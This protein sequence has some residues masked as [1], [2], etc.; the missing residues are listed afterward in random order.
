MMARRP[1]LRGDTLPLLGRLW[2]EWLAPHRATLAVVLVL[3]TVVGVATGLYPALI[4]AAFDAFDRKDMSALA[5]GPLIVIAVTSARGFALFGQTVLT[6]RVVTRVE[7]DMQAALYAHLIDADLAQLGRESPAAFTQRFTTDF[8]F[9]KEALTRI[10]TVLLRDVAMLAA[11]VIALVWMDPL[12]TLAAAVT[13]PLVAGPVNRIG[14][15]LRQVSTTTQEQMGATASLITESLQGARVAKTYALEGYLKDRAAQALD[16]V[17]RLKM[18]AA[19]ARGRLDP[20]MEIGG[21]LAVAGVLVLVGQR[22][23]SGDRTVGDFTGYVAALLLA[24]QPARALGTLNAI[25]QEAAAALTRY[26]ALMDEQPTIR[27]SASAR[28][29]TVSRGE[30]RFENVHFR[31]RAD[32]PALEGI[33]LVVPAG[34]TTALVGRS[35]SGKSSL[36]NLVPRLQDVTAGRVLIDGTDVR[37]VTIASLRAAIAVVSQEVVLFDDTVAANIGFGRP[38]ATQDE[39]EAAARAAAAHG[40]ISRLGEGYAFRVGPGGGRLSG[41]E[42][43]RISL[44]R[45]F[46]KNAPILLLDEATSALDSESEH[47]V[48]EA[49]ERLMRGRTTLV[50]AHRLSTV[51]EANRIAVLEA[52]RVIELGRHD[53]LVAASGTY[54]RL[55]RL[56]LSDDSGVP[57]A[58]AAPV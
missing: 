31:Y 29:L 39:I 7:A 9:I 58:Q 20:L 12:L 56:Q 41:G 33:D 21:G 25:L 4:K 51:R 40:F 28:P 27:E 53:E 3:I 55:H 32:A 15:R 45:A 44:A 30:I 13:A 35:G 50:I 36:L 24:A 22:V 54:A 19:N 2:R 37:D 52:G 23:M 42:R 48:Q 5:Y 46:L 10:S 1:L 6:N 16:E 43:Q 17:R 11:L 47:L 34:S 8:A 49:L 57:K 38:G 26:F 18:K 14:K